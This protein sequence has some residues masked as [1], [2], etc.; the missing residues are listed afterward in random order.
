MEDN[1]TD[2]TIIKQEYERLLAEKAILDAKE[3]EL[4]ALILSQ[5]RVNILIGAVEKTLSTY[6]T[7]RGFK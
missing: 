4:N 2:L 5:R 3:I 1:L 6:N 7:A